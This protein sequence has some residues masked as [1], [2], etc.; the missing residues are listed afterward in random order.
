MKSDGFHSQDY[1]CGKLGIKPGV[2]SI[3]KG[4]SSCV[5]AA[6]LLHEALS[7][8]PPLASCLK[9]TKSVLLQAASANLSH[10][11]FAQVSTCTLMTV[12]TV[13]S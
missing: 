3:S 4:I 13:L 12:M 9:Q 10:P 11:S 1:V 8:L 5:Q 2:H 6:I 7:C